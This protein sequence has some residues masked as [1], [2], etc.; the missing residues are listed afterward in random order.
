MNNIVSVRHQVVGWNN[1]PWC[2]G[3][4]LAMS[5]ELQLTYVD[6]SCMLV[7]CTYLPILVPAL[8]ILY[9]SCTYIIHTYVVLMAH[10]PC[11]YILHT[12]FVSDHRT[13]E[14][15]RT[16][17]VYG[18]MARSDAFFFGPEPKLLV[19]SKCSLLT[20]SLINELGLPSLFSVI[21]FAV[22][23]V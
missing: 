1:E 22:I 23:T 2:V 19:I 21:I 9:V 18:P 7:C 10:I 5:Y 14:P 16:R 11:T 6:V 12:G 4:L 20:T 8:R 17:T 3:E 13:I 15:D